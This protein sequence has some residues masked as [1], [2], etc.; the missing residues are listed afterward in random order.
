MNEL[1]EEKNILQIFLP[2]QSIVEPDFE[3]DYIERNPFVISS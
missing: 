2:V 1:D 3:S